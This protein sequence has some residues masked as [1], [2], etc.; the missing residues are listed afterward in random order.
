MLR[1]DHLGKLARLLERQDEA[2]AEGLLEI[3]RRAARAGAAL[4]EYRAALAS[5]GKLWGAG[6]F[7]AAAATVAK[8]WKQ[9]VLEEPLRQVGQH[10]V[11]RVPAVAAE[12]PYVEIVEVQG[13]DHRANHELLNRFVIAVTAP[14]VMEVTPPYG[15]Q[16]LCRPRRVAAGEAAFNGWSGLYPLG[17]EKLLAFRAAGGPDAGFP[18]EMF[19]VV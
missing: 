1:T 10:L 15:W 5:F 9:S 13:D 7:D 8:V 3:Y 11:Y 2:F 19:Q 17:R 18:R 14:E 6:D 4:A 12:Y 16:C